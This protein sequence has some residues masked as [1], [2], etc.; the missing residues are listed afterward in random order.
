M[1]KIIKLVS[2]E[3]LIGELEADSIDPAIIYDPM[4]IEVFRDEYYDAKLRLASAVSLSADDFLVF[5]RKHV[6]TH[7]TPQSILVEFY[8]QML[9]LV[10]EDKKYAEQKIEE[11]LEGVIQSKTEKEDFFDQLNEL[12]KDQGTDT[13]KH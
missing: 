13:T 6:L 3:T 2:G 4:I 8:R 9:P 5:E 1:I 11:A 7:Y 10:S 12:F